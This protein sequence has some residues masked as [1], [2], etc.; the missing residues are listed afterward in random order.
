MQSRGESLQDF[1]FDVFI[2]R[3][4]SE[5]L[6]SMA[7]KGLTG[8]VRADSGPC[9]EAVVTVTGGCTLKARPRI[10]PEKDRR[11]RGPQPEQWKC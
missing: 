7:V 2:G 10:P 8:G 1:K 4:P 11:D 5:T 3:F 6:A 9:G